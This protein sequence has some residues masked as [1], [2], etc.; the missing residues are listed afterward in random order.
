MLP[1][2]QR[3]GNWQHWEWTTVRAIGN[4]FEPNWAKMMPMG[5]TFGQKLVCCPLV[6]PTVFCHQLSNYIALLLVYG[7]QTKFEQTFKT[8]KKSLNQLLPVKIPV[9][10]NHLFG[11]VNFI[12]FQSRFGKICFHNVKSKI[13]LKLCENLTPGFFRCKIWRKMGCNDIIWLTTN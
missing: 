9:F 2:S 13:Y 10:E 3:K 11:I 4:T 1:C 6:S 8:D 12:K 7:I 5:N